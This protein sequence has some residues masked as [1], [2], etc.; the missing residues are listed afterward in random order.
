[1]ARVRLDRAAMDHMLRGRGGLVDDHIGRLTR[2]TTTLARRN[3][4]V[5]TGRARA[6]V[7]GRVRTHGTLV[8]GRVSSPLKYTLYLHEGTGIYGPRGHPI[9]PKNGKY[10]VFKPKGAPNYVY[11]RKVR[12][13]PGDEWLVRALRAA[14]PY[15]VVEH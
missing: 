7:H 1:M 2:R 9:T 8:I 6:S 14:V 11:A 15:P 3:M 4:R 10:L 12:G 5:D 13:I